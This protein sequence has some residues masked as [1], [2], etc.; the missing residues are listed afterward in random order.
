MNMLPSILNSSPTLE[1]ATW[2]LFTVRSLHVLY[3]SC[4]ALH[5][6]PSAAQ[7]RIFTPFC[8]PSSCPCGYHSHV[9]NGYA[10]ERL[11]ASLVASLVFIPTE[12]GRLLYPLTPWPPFSATPS[13]HANL[14]APREENMPPYELSFQSS[15]PDFSRDTILSPLNEQ[16]HTPIQPISQGNLGPSAKSS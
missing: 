13:C 7:S 14:Q 2:H 10:S 5:Q 4:S 12:G 3:C 1:V 9:T 8:G 11:I 6:K 16:K 15:T